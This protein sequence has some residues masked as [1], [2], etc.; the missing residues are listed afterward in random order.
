MS[1]VRQRRLQQRWPCVARTR[2][3][4]RQF[5]RAG[6]GHT[7]SGTCRSVHGMALRHPHQPC[8]PRAGTKG[9]NGSTSVIG[10]PQRLCAIRSLSFTPDKPSFAARVAPLTGSPSVARHRTEERGTAPRARSMHAQ[11]PRSRAVAATRS[12]ARP[13]RASGAAA[14]AAHR[15]AR[16][17]HPRGSPPACPKAGAAQA[18]CGTRM[19]WHQQRSASP[20]AARE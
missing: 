8:A 16:A 4:D 12:R 2:C 13:A 17:G 20:K 11:A 18:S 10:Q 5:R 6:C 19:A 9:S 3:P 14:P 7:G 15:A 1:S